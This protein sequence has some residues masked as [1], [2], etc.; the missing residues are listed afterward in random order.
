MSPDC[1]ESF[2]KRGGSSAWDEPGWFGRRA[3]AGDPRPAPPPRDSAVLALFPDISD[4][5][6]PDPALARDAAATAAPARPFAP[7]PGFAIDSPHRTANSP[8]A[9]RTG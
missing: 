5:S 4:R 2:A 6:P 8:S 7:V 3:S 1:G 9:S